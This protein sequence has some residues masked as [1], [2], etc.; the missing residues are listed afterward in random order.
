MTL[1]ANFDSVH[2][3]HNQEKD[4][5][6]STAHPPIGSMY[7][8]STYIFHK[9]QLSNVGKSTIHKWYGPEK[10]HLEKKSAKLPF[11]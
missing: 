5:Q 9:N 8:I 2:C 7:G 6:S 10:D 3:T 11:S 4:G 1:H